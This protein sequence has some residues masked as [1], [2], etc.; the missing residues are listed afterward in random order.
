MNTVIASIIHEDQAGFMPN[1][2]TAV[3]LRKLYVNIQIPADNMGSRANK[4]FDSVEWGYL[5]AV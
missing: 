3:N 5:W 1:K 4:A 2:S